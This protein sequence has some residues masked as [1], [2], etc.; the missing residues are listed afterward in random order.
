MIYDWVLILSGC[1]DGIWIDVSE[2][3]EKNRAI[4]E[5]SGVISLLYSLCDCLFLM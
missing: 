1:M 2:V 3:S 5:I 4:I